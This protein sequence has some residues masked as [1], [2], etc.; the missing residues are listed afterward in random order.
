MS[1]GDQR[2]CRMYLLQC[3]PP[4]QH[5]EVD[6]LCTLALQ[7]SGGWEG[8]NEEEEEEEGANRLTDEEGDSPLNES[9]NQIWKEIEPEDKRR[10][11]S[12]SIH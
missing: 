12:P 6:Q 9:Q 3:H 10:A 2:L 8:V 11:R 4:H 7:I 1:G 5:P